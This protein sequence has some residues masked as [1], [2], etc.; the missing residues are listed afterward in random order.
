MRVCL[1][2]CRVSQGHIR[3][4]E[5]LLAGPA[6]LLEEVLCHEVAH[7]AVAIKLGTGVRPHGGEWRGLMRDAGYEPRVRIS[8]VELARVAPAA[9]GR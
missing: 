8:D 2:R 9:L 1:G 3:I 5:F 7:A 4:A 6:D